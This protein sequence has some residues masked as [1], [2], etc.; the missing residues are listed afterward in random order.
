MR[1]PITYAKIAKEIHKTAALWGLPF[2]RYSRAERFLPFPPVVPERS[3]EGG[4][5]LFRCGGSAVFPTLNYK[6]NA[7]NLAV[8]LG[9]VI[10]KQ[11][12]QFSFLP[13]SAVLLCLFK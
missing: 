1:C 12:I 4:R 2:S 3:V 13:I 10:P 5:P 8:I 9:R 7:A 11:V 6:H